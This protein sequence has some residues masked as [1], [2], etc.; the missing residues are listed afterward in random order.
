MTLRVWSLE[1]KDEVDRMQCDYP[2]A[3]IGTVIGNDNL[4]S[5]TAEGID[6]WKIKHIHTSQTLIG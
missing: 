1:A 3:G 6:L 2:V 5:F 4:Y